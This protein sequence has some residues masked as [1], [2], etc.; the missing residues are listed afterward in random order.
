MVETQSSRN[1]SQLLLVGRLSDEKEENVTT[2]TL[3]SENQAPFTVAQL[4]QKEIYSRI[5]SNIELIGLYVET[6]DK[7]ISD[8]G[9]RPN[10]IFRDVTQ[11]LHLIMQALDRIEIRLTFAHPWFP[12]GQ[13]VS[14][15]AFYNK[16]NPVQT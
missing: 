8:P 10:R 12:P 1:S 7:I 13:F 9:S 14:F 16:M 5:S 6:N 4:T 3:T 11:S 15:W 2:D